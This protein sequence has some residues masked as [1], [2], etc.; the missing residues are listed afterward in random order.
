VKILLYIFYVVIILVGFKVGTMVSIEEKYIIGFI[1]GCFAVG[2]I[3][4]ANE[5]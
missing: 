1:F 3:Q 4:I 5:M 2:I